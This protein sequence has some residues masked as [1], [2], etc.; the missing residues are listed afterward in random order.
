M[1]IIGID[2][3]KRSHTAAVIE[4]DEHVRDTVRVIADGTQQERL[5]DW[6]TDYTPRTW[7][8]EGASGLGSLLAQQLVRAGE[9]VVDVP[10]ALSARARYLDSGRSDKSDPHD[11]R[12]AAIVALRHH[13]LRVVHADDDFQVL[14]MFAVRHHQL[15]AGRTRAVCRLHA[16]V[17]LMVEGGLA[18]KASYRRAI[19]ALEEITPV[20]PV[21]VER[22]R[23]A[24][25]FVEEVH[26]HD[27]ALS[28]LR[29]RIVTAVDASGSTVTDVFGVGPIV[30]AYLIGHSGDVHRFASKGHYARYCATAPIQASSGPVKRHRLNPAGN[31]QLN[32]AIHMAAVTQIAH[33]TPG[34]VYYQRKLAEGKSKKEAMRCLKRRITDVIYARLQADANQS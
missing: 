30:A 7:A 29:A 4:G 26:R 14:R 9:S 28:E 24:Y 20:S 2:P 3:H 27:T 5:L 10:P 18:K 13:H 23:Y 12:S 19:T 15:T 16:I 8:I 22:H 6:A 31:R 25:E 17:A 1:F 34:R 32:H 33:D 11:A 21:D